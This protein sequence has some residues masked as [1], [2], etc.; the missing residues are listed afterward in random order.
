MKVAR[1]KVVGLAGALALGYVADAFSAQIKVDDKTWAN[2]GLNMKIWY[3]NLD[4]RSNDTAAGGWT[5][6]RFSVG[7]TK[8]YFTGQVTPVFQFYSE[9]DTRSTALAAADKSWICYS[10]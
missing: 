7:Q 9:L 3:H 6:N 4:K 2:F 1:W 5:Q 8:I 10:R